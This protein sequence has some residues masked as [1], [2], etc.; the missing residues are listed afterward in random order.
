ME[1][2]KHS[3]KEHTAIVDILKEMKLDEVVLVGPESASVVKRKKKNWQV[4]EDTAELKKWHKAAKMDETHVL[5]K[6]S[7]SVSLESILK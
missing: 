3:Q 4:F 7:R 1:L 6:G 2:G 5:I